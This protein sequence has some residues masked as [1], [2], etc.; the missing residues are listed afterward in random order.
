MV[1]GDRITEPS[2]AVSVFDFREFGE[3]FIGALEERW[4]VDIG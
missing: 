1:S 2:Q 4:V 3:L